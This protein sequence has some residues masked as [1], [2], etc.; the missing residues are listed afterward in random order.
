MG[1]FWAVLGQSEAVLG[2]L[3]AILGQSEA[4]LG[5]SGAIWGLSPPPASFFSIG[6]GPAGENGGVGVGGGGVGGRFLSRFLEKT[7]TFSPRDPGGGEGKQGGSPAHPKKAR[8]LLPGAG[9]TPPP[10]CRVLRGKVAV[11]GQKQL[12]TPPQNQTLCNRDGS[13]DPQGLENPETE[14]FCPIL[15]Q[16]EEEHGENPKTLGFC[17][18]FALAEG[19]R[20][21]VRPRLGRGQEKEKGKWGGKMK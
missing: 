5:Q 13:R 4:V 17:P 21:G 12:P 20:R 3:R 14:G 16:P 9:G 19:G 6:G 18:N 1:P 10:P 8:R 7:G 2:Q 15:S 11:L